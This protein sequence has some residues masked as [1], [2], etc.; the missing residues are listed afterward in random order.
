MELQAFK[1]ELK[2]KLTGGLLNLELDDTAL[3]TLISSALR[4]IQRY[5]DES[6]IITVPFQRCIDLSKYNVNSVSAIYRTNTANMGLNN[7]QGYVDPMWLQQWQLMGGAGEIQYLSNFQSNY[8]A[9]NTLLQIRNTISTDLSY[10]FD[11]SKNLLYINTIDNIPQ[12]ITIEFIPIYNSVADI[13]TDYWID[14]T[15][16]LA[17]A[18]GKVALGHIRTRFTQSNALWTQNGDSIL[19]EGKDELQAVRQHL[20]ENSQLTYPMD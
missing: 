19:Q 12:C 3:T 4:E 5:I 11:K 7:T 8:G 1:N 9:W 2:F 6:Y 18:L 14:L 15:M 17:V 20:E 16:R 10:Y 13:K